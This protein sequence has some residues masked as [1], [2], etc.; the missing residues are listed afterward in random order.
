MV[1]VPRIRERATERFAGACRLL[2]FSGL[3]N[4]AWQSNCIR[5]SYSSY[6]KLLRPVTGARVR[7]RVINEQDDSPNGGGDVA[8]LSHRCWRELFGGR[9]EVLG[10]EFRRDETTYTII[11]VAPPTFTGIDPEPPPTFG[12]R[13]RESAMPQCFAP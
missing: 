6:G 5:D 4:W 2:S 8:V 9:D 13:C 11:G 12:F 3:R 1:N 7:G 10:T